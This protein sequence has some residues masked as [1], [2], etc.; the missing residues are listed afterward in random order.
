M[1]AKVGQTQYSPI[2]SD[3][4]DAAEAVATSLLLALSLK[5][6]C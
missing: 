4:L 3:W 6:Q 1:G 5:P 2:T